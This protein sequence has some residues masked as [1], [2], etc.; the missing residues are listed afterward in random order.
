MTLEC[1]ERLQMDKQTAEDRVN[2]YFAELQHFLSVEYEENMELID[3][4]INNY[5][6]LANTRILLMAS[7]GEKM[8]SVLH[9]FLN[10]IGQLPEAEQE[11]ASE[12]VGDA[13]RITQQ[14]YIGNRSFEKKRK[15][16]NTG[17]NIGLYKEELTEEDKEAKTEQLFRQAQNRYSV[18]RTGDYLDAQLGMAESLVIGEKPILSREE[19]LMYAAAMA[20][21]GNEEFP[22]EVELGDETVETE[23]A[24]ISGARIRRK[25]K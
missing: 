3:T 13:L 9:D 16:K 15:V 22:F 7:S 12:K 17:E 20:Y 5:Y 10:A 8:E 4:R 2:R 6:N 18:E 23:T 11:T 25:S 24:E 14:R 19:V 1:A 21:A